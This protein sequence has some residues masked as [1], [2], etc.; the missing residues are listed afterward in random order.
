MLFLSKDSQKDLLMSLL[1][2]RKINQ[3]A[4]TYLRKFA[5][6]VRSPSLI[7]GTDYQ[8]VVSFEYH[9][10]T[11]SSVS[12]NNLIFSKKQKISHLI[13]WKNENIMEQ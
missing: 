7:D 11:D 2:Q 9:S 12:A 1:N 6:K 3:F 10:S 5:K 13:L 8:C 4:E